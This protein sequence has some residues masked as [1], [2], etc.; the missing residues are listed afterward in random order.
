MGNGK[1]EEQ[2]GAKAGGP[3][4]C[5]GKIARLESRLIIRN[6]AAREFLAEFLGT[7]VFM[8]ST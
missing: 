8:V 4:K 2:E 7:Y 3:A 6:E 1:E 5:F